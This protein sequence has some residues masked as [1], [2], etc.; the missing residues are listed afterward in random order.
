M[1]TS[2]NRHR[3]DRSK[4]RYPSD[5]TDPEWALIEPHIPPAKRDGNKAHG[6]GAPGS[7]PKAKLWRWPGTRSSPFQYI[8]DQPQ[9]C[10]FNPNLDPQAVA[11]CELNLNTIRQWRRR[12]RHGRT[13]R[14]HQGTRLGA[15]EVCD[16]VP[17]RLR[18]V[19]TM[20]VFTLYWR[21]TTDTEAPG[22]PAAATISRFSASGQD[23]CRR[24]GFAFVSIIEFVDTS[25]TTN[26][27]M[28][29]S[30]GAHRLRSK[31]AL[32]GGIPKSR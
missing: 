29:A 27:I 23:L 7:Q 15:G 26:I 11:A 13:R 31:A 22:S 12:C 14:H 5:L 30:I 9:G 4:L 6:G 19:N 32:T 17:Y 20:L 8:Q 10:G 28:P 18:Q 2:G 25:H 16:A 21:A 3:Y 24:L 1:W